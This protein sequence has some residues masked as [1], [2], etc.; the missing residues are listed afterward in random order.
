MLKLQDLP[1]NEEYSPP[2]CL[3]MFDRRSFGR[4][5]YAG[6]SIVPVQSCLYHP[7]LAEEREQKLAGVGIKSFDS[8]NSQAGETD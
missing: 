1:T 7:L 3:K 8:R 2:L 6:T 5:T 4:S